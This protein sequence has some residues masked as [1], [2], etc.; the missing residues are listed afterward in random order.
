MNGIVDD[1]KKFQK[2]FDVKKEQY[3]QAKWNLV[4]SPE[5]SRMVEED[6]KT[7]LESFFDKITT[8][9]LKHQGLEDQ[10]EFDRIRESFIAENLGKASPKKK[11]R[12]F[13]PIDYQAGETEKLYDELQVGIED[14][15]P[16]ISPQ[17][18]IAEADAIKGQVTE[19][20]IRERE[21]L[22][23]GRA[24]TA[25]Q[26]EKAFNDLMSDK[27][28]GYI[29]DNP[30]G[31]LSILHTG[32]KRRIERKLKEDGYDNHVIKK[33]IP[34]LQQYAESELVSKEK[35][36]TL[37]YTN[38]PEV[39][40]KEAEPYIDGWE[41]GTFLDPETGLH[42]K[43][44]TVEEADIVAY[45][46]ELFET[47][48]VPAEE[49]PEITEL[50]EEIKTLDEEGVRVEGLRKEA[51]DWVGKQDEIP[52][53]DFLIGYWD[54][55]DAWK[56]AQLDYIQKAK[57]IKGRVSQ[58][59][60]EQEGEL[61]DTEKVLRD[62]KNVPFVK[63]ILQGDKGPVRKN[64]DGTESSH[65]M[66][67]GEADGKYYVYPTLT[68]KDGKWDEPE[69]PM[70]TALDEKNYIAFDDKEKAVEFAA[71]SWK[72]V[73]EKKKEPTSK[74]TPTP[75][76]KL[77]D[78]MADSF[79]K[80]QYWQRRLEDGK[81][82]FQTGKMSRKQ[83]D[84][85]LRNK[86]YAQADFQAHALMAMKNVGPMDITKEDG[87][88]AQIFGN[89]AL[90]SF[91]GEENVLEASPGSIDA[92]IIHKLAQ[93][94]NETV[95]LTDE[96]KKHIEPVMWE[97]FFEFT[98]SAV[99]HLPLL[100]IS[101]GVSKFAKG[102]MKLGRLKNG[103]KIIRHPFYKAPTVKPVPLGTRQAPKGLPG[104]VRWGG[105]EP[106]PHKAA[107][108]VIGLKDPVPIGWEV[109]KEVNPTR[110]SR[111]S[112]IALEFLLDEAI[113]TGIGG[114]APGVISGMNATHTLTDR[115]KFKSKVGRIF[116]PLLKT[117]LGTTAG[118]EVGFTTANAVEAAF[119]ADKSFKEAWDQ[120]WGNMDEAGKRVVA[121][122]IFNTLLFGPLQLYSVTS[123]KKLSDP[124][125]GKWY[126]YLSP[127]YFDRVKKTS[128]QAEDL[129]MTNTAERMYRWLDIYDGPLATEGVK[130]ARIA[131]KSEIA[132]SFED[133]WLE[134][135]L[136]NYENA[137]TVVENTRAKNKFPT[138]AKWKE[139]KAEKSILLN[140]RFHTD[141]L[142][143][144][145][146]ENR[147]VFN[148]EMETR[149]QAGKFM[150]AGLK[151]GEAPM[152]PALPV[153][154]GGDVFPKQTLTMTYDRKVYQEIKQAE[155]WEGNRFGPPQKALEGTIADFRQQWTD[156]WMETDK[157]TEPLKKEIT[158]IDE[159]LG[160]FKGRKDLT[161]R[162]EID[163]LKE[164]K[165][166]LINK[167][168]KAFQ[169]V[170]TEN[171]QLQEGVYDLVR[172]KIREIDP[173]MTPE[174]IE[175]EVNVLADQI[176]N[177][178]IPVDI[179]AKQPMEEFINKWLG[180]KYLEEKEY[181]EGRKQAGEKLLAAIEKTRE[182]LPEGE[183]IVFEH[184]TRQW[185]DKIIKR[186]AR[187]DKEYREV[188]NEKDLVEFEKQVKVDLIETEQ[189]L[190]KLKPEEPEVKKKGKPA[191]AKPQ[192]FEILAKQVSEKSEDPEEIV[193]IY[194]MGQ[195]HYQ[196]K[197]VPW[198]ER[199][200]TTKVTKKSLA[201]FGDPNKFSM[202]MMKNWIGKKDPITKQYA[203]G[204]SKI[205]VLAKDMTE[206]FG[207]E[208]TT[209]MIA[210]F[211][212]E[213]PSKQK[214]EAK[215]P[216]MKELEIR[217]KEVAGMSIDKYIEDEQAFLKG[218][219][220]SDFDF[221]DVM[222]MLKEEEGIES[223][224]LKDFESIR[225]KYFTG[226]PFTEE[227]GQIVK[228]YL[229]E[230]E[231]Q[232]KK[233]GEEPAEGITPTKGVGVKG[234]KVEGEPGEVDISVELDEMT[235]LLGDIDFSYG[236]PEGRQTD[237]P[238]EIK[239][240]KVATKIV[241]RFVGNK[242]YKFPEMIKKV[243]GSVTQEKLERLLPYLKQGYGAYMT[244]I[245]ADVEDTVFEKMD[246]AQA[247]RFKQEDIGEIYQAMHEP[248][249]KEDF[250]DIVGKSFLFP[251]LSKGNSQKVLDIIRVEEWDDNDE[252]LKKY[253]GP[254]F[255][256]KPIGQKIMVAVYSDNSNYGGSMLGIS[257][258]QLRG[259]IKSG[260]AVA[261]PPFKHMQEWTELN[262]EI[263][264]QRN[265]LGETEDAQK[266]LDRGQ[267][268]PHVSLLEKREG[269]AD[270]LWKERSERMIK[271]GNERL[272]ARKIYDGEVIP[273]PSDK[274]T[275]S[276][277]EDIIFRIDGKRKK[278]IAEFALKHDPD[279]WRINL[280]IINESNELMALSGAL[281][282]GGNTWLSD[283][284]DW[285][286]AS[287]EDWLSL[288]A[289][290]QKQIVLS[291]KVA[292]PKRLQHAQSLFDNDVAQAREKLKNARS[293]LLRNQIKNDLLNGRRVTFTTVKALLPGY[294]LTLT[295][296]EIRDQ[297]ELA[298]T[299]RFRDIARDRNISEQERFNKLVTF[300]NTQP[301]LS[302]L[303]SEVKGKQQYSTPGPLAFMMHQYVNG[304][305]A[306]YIGD[307]SAG[308]G[309][310]VIYADP[311]RVFVNDLSESRYKNLK[312]LGFNQVAN[313]DATKPVK[314]T[315]FDFMERHF[316]AVVLNPPFGSV[317][318]I[319]MKGFDVSRIEHIIAMN[320]LDLMSD[321]G[322]AAIIAG[323]HL[324]VDEDGAIKGG[325]LY[326]YNWLYKNYVVDGIVNI[327]GDLYSRMGTSWPIRLIMIGGRKP[328]PEGVAPMFKEEGLTPAV[329]W[330]DVYKNIND[331]ISK[332]NEKALLRPVM[333]EGGG[334]DTD[335]R[336]E[337]RVDEIP[338]TQ[339]DEAPPLPKATRP[340]TI[341]PPEEP[342]PNIPG[343]ISQPVSP[344]PGEAGS[345]PG[346]IPGTPRPD[347]GTSGDPTGEGITTPDET[348]R[349]EG[350]VG[351][352][353]LG[354]VAPRSQ[355]KQQLIIKQAG[356][357]EPY[358]PLSKGP[359]GETVIPLSQANEMEDALYQLAGEIGDFDNY[360]MGKLNYPSRAD[361]YKAFYAEQI[362]ALA[363][364][365]Y[366][367][368]N[369]EAVIIGDQT[370]V[371]KGRVAAGILRYAVNN[372]YRPIFMT[373][374]AG[375]YSDIYRDL[376]GIGSG[377]LRPFMFNKT[378]AD[379]SGA[380]IIT[381]PEG[382]ELYQSDPAAINKAM[383]EGDISE[384]YNV[385]LVSYSQLMTDKT[386][387][388]RKKRALFENLARNNIVV[389]DESHLASG[390]SNV[391]FFLRDVLGSADG[392]TF[393]SATYAKRPDNLPLY[394]VNTVIREAAL[395]DE[396]LAEAIKA[397]GPALME[398]IS[399]QLVESMQLIRR[400]RSMKGIENNWIV[401]GRDPE[402][403]KINDAGKDILKKYDAVTDLV[404]QIISFQEMFVKPIIKAWNAKLK[405]EGKQM[406]ERRGTTRMGVQN[407]PYFNKIYNVINQLLFTLK[408]QH[409][410]PTII[411]QLE[412]GQK[413]FVAFSNT[414]ES[415]FKHMMDE[416]LVSMGDEVSTNFSYVLERGLKGVMKA[417][418]VDETGVP[419]PEYL[420]PGVLGP[421]GQETYYALLEK[422]REIGEEISAS[423]IDIMIHEIEKA[424]YKV[425]EITGRKTKI[426]FTGDNY[427]KG[428]LVSN[429][430]PTKNE[431]IRKFNNEPGWVIL[432]NVASSTGLS[433]HSSVD[434]KDQ[435]QR[436]MT[437]V[438]PEPDINAYMQKIGRIHRAGQVTDP[439]YNNV[440]SVVPAEQRLLMMTRQKIGMLDANTT[441][442]QKQS[443][444]MLDIVD[445]LN[446]YGDQVVE[447]Y[448]RDNLDIN[449]L[450]GDPLGIVDESKNRAENPT[451]KVTNEVSILTTQQQEEFYTDVID[452]YKALIDYLNE[453][454]QNDLEVKA[455]DLQAESINKDLVIRGRGG[456]S[457][458][459]DDSFMELMDVNSMKNPMMAKEI[460]DLINK[461]L[462]G[463]T[464]EAHVEDTYK[465]IYDGLQKN[466]EKKQQEVTEMYDIKIKEEHRR[467]DEAVEKG[468]NV[469]DAEE[470]RK[471]KINKL[472]EFRGYRLS[473]VQKNNTLL[474]N[475]IDRYI[476]FFKVGEIYE[477]A[478]EEDIGNIT[479]MNK[480]YVV[481]Y[482]INVN[483]LN[484]W[485][486]SNIRIKFATADSRR[487]FQVP[488]SKD[489]YLD[490]IIASSYSLSPSERTSAKEQWDYHLKGAGKRVKR[491]IVTNNILQAFKDYKGKLIEFT[492]KEGLIKKGILLPD[493]FEPRV[494]KMVTIAIKDAK[495]IIL[496][497]ANKDY[498]ETTDGHV[499]I[500][501][502]IPRSMEYNYGDYTDDQLYT[503]RVPSSRE[504][505]AKYWDASKS[506]LPAIM[507]DGEFTQIN[508][509]FNGFFR[510]SQLDEVL[511]IL[512]DYRLT[513]ATR[514]E[515]VAQSA[516]NAA[517]ALHGQSSVVQDFIDTATAIKRDSDLPPPDE[518]IQYENNTGGR[519]GRISPDPLP[520]EGPPKKIWEIQLSIPRKFRAGVRYQK[521]R[522]G[523]AG[524]YV[525]GEEM[526]ILKYQ[527]DLDVTAH[528]LGHRI[529]D[530]FGIVGPEVSW[531][532]PDI[533]HELSRLWKYGSKP[534]KDTLDKE[535]YRRSE[536]TAE[537][538]RAWIINPNQTEKDFP[539]LTEWFKE[540]V[541]DE[542][543]EVIRE[544]GD[545]IRRYVGSTWME[546][547]QSHADFKLKEQPE[548]LF[549]N[550][551]HRKD[552]NAL[553]LKW[554]W[555]DKIV[556]GL[557]NDMWP[558]QKAFV[559][560]LKRQGVVK[561]V[562]QAWDP[563]NVKPSENPLYM[564]SLLAGHNDKMVA[565]FQH[566]MQMPDGKTVYDPVT[567]K[568]VNIVWMLDDL[569]K[570]DYGTF[571]KDLH[572]A[573]TY[574]IAERSIELEWKIQGDQVM[575]D[576]KN[577]SDKLPPLEILKLH[578]AIAEKYAVHINRITEWVIEN[579]ISDEDLYFP[580]ERYDFSKGVYTGI[581]GGFVTDNEAAQ[582]LLKEVR[583][584]KE[585]VKRWEEFARKYRFFGDNLIEYSIRSGLL[586]QE[587][588]QYIR[589]RNLS[590]VA[591]ARLMV[592]SPDE[593]WDI[594]KTEMRP[595]NR[596]GI[597]VQFTPDW[598]HRAKGSAKFIK[599]PLDQLLYLTTRTIQES[600]YNNYK[601]QLFK[602]FVP[603]RE[604]YSSEISGLAEL[605]RRVPYKL[606]KSVGFKKYGEQQ[607]WQ[608]DPVFYN[609]MMNVAESVPIPILSQM[610][611]IFRSSVVFNLVF[612][613]R[614]FERDV[615]FAGIT[616][617]HRFKLK[618]WFSPAMQKWSSEM[619]NRMGGG[620][621]GWYLTTDR[622]YYG[623]MKVAMT[624]LLKDKSV[625][626]MNPEHLKT[627]LWDRG[628]ERF[629]KS[630][631][632]KPRTAIFSSSYRWAKKK[633]MVDY[634]ALLYAG[635]QGRRIMD[636]RVMGY[637]IRRIAPNVPFLNP[638]IRGQAKSIWK[639][640]QNPRGT[641]IRLAIYGAIITALQTSLMAMLDDRERKEY[642][643]FPAWRRDLFM[644]FPTPWGGWISIPRAFDLGILSSGMQRLADKFILG[645][646]KAFDNYINSTLFN[647]IFPFR[648]YNLSS[649]IGGITAITT[650]K[651]F[652]RDKYYIPPEEF[653]KDIRERNTQW[654]SQFGKDVMNMTQFMNNFFR[655][656]GT[657]EKPPFID[658]RMV[659]AFVNAQFTYFGKQ[660]IDTYQAVRGKAEDSRHKWDW[661]DTG[662]FRYSNVYGSK[663]VQWIM[664]TARKHELFYEPEYR[665]LSELLNQYF[666]IGGAKER[667]RF[668]LE[669][670][671]YAENLRSQW[672][673]RDFYEEHLEKEKKRKARKKAGR[674]KIGP[675][676]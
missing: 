5:F 432:G 287:L 70:K 542:F 573:M 1:K 152:L 311:L 51:E 107:K 670:I 303:T 141:L 645:D 176:L 406:E 362:D 486:P 619:M 413:P 97:R 355:R 403:G 50:G 663:D 268:A 37:K 380:V 402:T 523:I 2:G 470:M 555:A 420:D 405:A 429:P 137:I 563:L 590:Y 92:A 323:G 654:A 426:E 174:Q 206:E 60:K 404:R 454:D 565:I 309:M 505:G 494:D 626:V 196:P 361:M 612:Y 434:F 113:F 189:K 88:Y 455:L 101:S 631:E 508:Q 293:Y 364:A 227:E 583:K 6:K 254:L 32:E 507:F 417:T 115:I 444:K 601:V 47:A 430:R 185:R 509:S 246:I 446:K 305:A 415:M 549:E 671:D 9:Y 576:L 126:S 253:G 80:L 407:Y 327:E 385:I 57:G 242:I 616:H 240:A 3:N 436:V 572:D 54:R 31:F 593:A 169:E 159:K 487:S 531:K 550:F 646:D 213:N 298:F 191:P 135:T 521:P 49:D 283:Y 495:N 120:Q 437:I 350:D 161:Q 449:T 383:D 99:P 123:A 239:L 608:V 71:G 316:P 212:M 318:K 656:K 458:F 496:A 187:L 662:Q 66:A 453:T 497:L 586:S 243:A 545:D 229:Y 411:Q 172:D 77:D 575:Y 48:Q 255:A 488:L 222:E 205:D 138:Q 272:E 673:T 567:N 551:L 637:Y 168:E 501:K 230:K 483:K 382:R 139:G 369:G 414:M 347:I 579:N 610:A 451:R 474:T 146:Y 195:E 464:A 336:I 261:P 330:G 75:Q 518:D 338:P 42:R 457:A 607:W 660:F 116:G 609:G 263:A 524:F 399:S 91:V 163:K 27:E 307:N 260:E 628:Y 194:Q 179:Y 621:F 584:N 155:E 132:K 466:L 648:L 632:R 618:D 186:G 639:M 86:G 322:K 58:Y 337:R 299:E 557:S 425:A 310:L 224:T 491:Y 667:Q 216:V 357:V 513:I 581:G 658:A 221:V 412:K 456:F 320:G 22:K 596:R 622:Q 271:I 131:S 541:P 203:A 29:K 232:S 248:A 18:F 14:I 580:I 296:S 473:T 259:M 197:L 391:G 151:E 149:K 393:L 378:F 562:V 335:I 392:A 605:A 397:G 657:P 520:S 587:A 641:T 556:W 275:V 659:D 226:F 277:D 16:R 209:D 237:S 143:E 485:V 204:T 207:I 433:A 526:I 78:R 106:V 208:V 95:G 585:D 4:N 25:L 499:S 65:L 340:T 498:V 343:D 250:S 278:P 158:E 504:K 105:E 214:A 319:R 200:L 157:Q 181:I 547:A 289:E 313:F 302:K 199:L 304:D 360:V 661:S 371:G 461:E 467:Y 652:F 55:T 561:N 440:S 279:R 366:N 281:E 166:V 377:E 623:L 134:S 644:N 529:D 643:Q 85:L 527:G 591:L 354:A 617:D 634:D 306:K 130:E 476:K 471:D 368:S 264:R 448:L 104:I 482:D 286:K 387:N 167:I 147:G 365:L 210:E 94:G 401:Y 238:N 578:P 267:S 514:P 468:K 317:P 12:D 460:D 124:L 202:A 582:A 285:F 630:G 249:K 201:E 84:D 384:E 125:G 353:V 43:P 100:F 333:D 241:E 136:K 73:A 447:E 328:I 160:K 308:N 270:P 288:I 620:Q 653:Y 40:R 363:M 114:F 64:E 112:A 291:Y 24:E 650:K 117:T 108:S 142:L 379:G 321:D 536:G 20:G 325:D 175:D 422:I 231:K 512:D 599:D 109:I 500:M 266:Y 225:E 438:Q 165:G 595:G 358:R 62:N 74:P 510:E 503:L 30:G 217:F 345:I 374:D 41:E 133:R 530:M 642:F 292:D 103:Y 284:V 459:G 625:I 96:E 472:E 81:A 23:E 13:S 102:A 15:L 569:D 98:G 604:M 370:G 334:S 235:G 295:D 669:V 184:P 427:M 59:N 68:Y 394:G 61:S 398:I 672:E 192:D 431:L 533:N 564:G 219:D 183:E 72:E 359:S 452:R 568:Q 180:E 228:E 416:G 613:L 367:I 218:I 344:G 252:G 543:L 390:Q 540:R 570:T 36:T 544:F 234:K 332:P 537:Y 346:R 150:Q 594:R 443:E 280:D 290:R 82:A 190:K 7:E 668:G 129:G 559:E 17:T 675:K 233:A 424:G 441:S 493:N 600:D 341:G 198:Q 492:T 558:V 611:T 312:T 215:D 140:N 539:K 372:G 574:M 484:P 28:F 418:V 592:M 156:Q 519:V 297:M 511:Q 300:Y 177:G 400:E 93:I 56:K 522:K 348:I 262:N 247:R 33:I 475:S 553:G 409:I 53:S 381:D 506:K 118:M 396:E 39:A 314:D 423:P 164:Q 76:E 614:N 244:T 478:Y 294:G 386:E 463:K 615:S 598:M 90:H 273:K 69:D 44:E 554:G 63:R 35:E 351:R 480:G 87:Y 144:D 331:L 324:E 38:I 162:R 636:F 477:V 251:N 269:A 223:I 122:M 193:R 178:E 119:S 127:K 532:I 627:V 211:I 26:A 188:V 589:E 515:K 110:I 329:T 560:A 640:R 647:L 265:A 170:T 83:Y 301:S 534:K 635:L 46:Q 67:W 588:G 538:I 257:V 465:K 462:M 528:E 606:E 326:F 676:R 419:H 34:M 481:G 666:D 182:K 633:G 245:G 489:Q 89:A 258:D 502:G 111:S 282:M 388:G 664:K 445:I 153:S 148:F 629:M 442:N 439:I 469:R 450:I 21:S 535:A 276:T 315:D 421:A 45:M 10:L 256:E 602:W 173:D 339:P 121:E 490:T 52:R 375:L 665:A 479:R 349:G 548:S 154:E 435:S 649:A 352:I 128:R 546:R 517:E 552:N 373:K 11:E 376:I 236:S 410:T 603:T 79:V 638:M 19:L 525:P 408:A 395:T 516:F 655:K 566:G 356:G 571:V 145:L 8:P 651:D 577:Y 674:G 171:L 342:G 389:M 597:G 274:I 220:K 428:K 624:K